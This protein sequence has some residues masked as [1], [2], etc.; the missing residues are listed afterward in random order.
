MTIVWLK[1][2]IKSVTNR[3]M[4]KAGILVEKLYL[5]ILIAYWK[6]ILFIYSRFCSI[7]DVMGNEE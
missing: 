7:Y 6:N 1:Q 2:Y 4:K 3:Q 5:Y